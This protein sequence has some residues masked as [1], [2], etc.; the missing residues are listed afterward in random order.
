M[1]GPGS[2]GNVLAALCSFLFPGLGQLLQGRLLAAGIQFVLSIALWFMF[3]GWIVH[4][5]S[6]YDAATYVPPIQ[7]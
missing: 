1:S 3:L 7:T 6:A 2:G 4:L 5:W